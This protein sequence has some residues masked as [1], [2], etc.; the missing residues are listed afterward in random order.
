MTSWPCD[1]HPAKILK[2]FLLKGDSRYPLFRCNLRRLQDM[3]NIWNYFIRLYQLPGVAGSCSV[4]E[5]RRGYFSNL[6]RLNPSGIIPA[7][8]LLKLPSVPE[9]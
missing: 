8:P 6:K 3:P 1:F 4:D 7:G 9:S 2:K 5:Y